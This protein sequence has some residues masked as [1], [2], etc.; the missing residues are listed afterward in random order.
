MKILIILAVLVSTVY[1]VGPAEDE[2]IKA[3]ELFNHGNGEK[4]RDNALFYFMEAAKKGDARGMYGIGIWFEKASSSKEKIAADFYQCL[5]NQPAAKGTAR[6]EISDFFYRMAFPGLKELAEKGDP[7]A[8][9]Q[10]GQCYSYGDGVEKNKEQAIVWLQKAADQGEEAAKRTLFREQPLKEIAKFFS[11][12][13]KKEETITSSKPLREIHA[14]D[15]PSPIPHHQITEIYGNSQ[16]GY[17]IME[18]A[19]LVDEKGRITSSRGDLN[20]PSG[21]KPVVV[22]SGR[23]DNGTEWG[24]HIEYVP[25]TKAELSRDNAATV[26]DLTLQF[27]GNTYTALENRDYKSAAGYGAATIGAIAILLHILKGIKDVSSK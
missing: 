25:K 23:P 3:R 13:D 16:K 18:R 12:S 21:M 6:K 8:Q 15:R 24:K 17:G 20:P 7:V 2:V 1:A 19:T 4:D 10:L 5:F 26:L 22:H 27:G 9:F 14:N 11:G